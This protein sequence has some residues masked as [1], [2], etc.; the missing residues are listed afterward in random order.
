MT[1]NLFTVEKDT[2]SLYGIVSLDLLLFC[3][4]IEA[5][6]NKIL[7]WKV[8]GA[9]WVWT[10]DLPSSISPEE[11][12]TRVIEKMVRPELWDDEFRDGF[13]VKVGQNPK[14]GMIMI[15]S[16]SDMK[17]QDEHLVVLSETVVANAGLHEKAA[18][19]KQARE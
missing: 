11:V 12:A 9:N 4:M 6:L 17:S 18:I 2:G 1:Q 10:G 16:H 7:T 15:L 5:M 19:L 13:L 14:V 3:G 8:E